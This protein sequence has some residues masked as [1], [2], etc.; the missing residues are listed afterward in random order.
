MSDRAKYLSLGASLP[1]ECSLMNRANLGD[2][3][4]SLVRDIVGYLNFSSGTPDPRFL[5]EPQ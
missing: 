3:L 1:E 5:E 2:D 4:S